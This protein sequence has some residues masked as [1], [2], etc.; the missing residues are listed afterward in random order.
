MID[1]NKFLDFHFFI[2]SANH[3]AKYRYFPKLMAGD[4]RHNQI[5]H[6][7]TSKHHF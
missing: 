2:C 5:M 4:R 6:K 7:D 1:Y 3:D